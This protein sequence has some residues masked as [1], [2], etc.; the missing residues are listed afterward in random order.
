MRTVL[1]IALWCCPASVGA[2][3]ARAHSACGAARGCAPRCAP[4][5]GCAAE[6][7]GDDEDIIEDAQ[8]RKRRSKG[9]FAPYKPPRDER[10]RLLYDVTEITPPPRRLGRFRLARDASCGDM[11][12]HKDSTF[13]I[14]AVDYR[15]QYQR[16]AYRMVGK[17]AAV[18]ES[19]REA[20][21]RFFARMLPDEQP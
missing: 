3:H 6:P 16:G 11:L 5:R 15:Y 7:L 18:K 14:K 12:E 20:T 4:L 1:G 10:D 9:S 13:V 21:E 19:S 17:S 8:V 2:A